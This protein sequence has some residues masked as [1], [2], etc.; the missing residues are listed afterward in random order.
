MAPLQ[1]V[2]D[3]SL[4]LINKRPDDTDQSLSLVYSSNG[5]SFLKERKCSEQDWK[6][7]QNAENIFTVSLIAIIP[8][9][10]SL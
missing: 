10:A 9:V 5:K 6:K 1:F 4:I 8:A 3:G 7:K 2:N